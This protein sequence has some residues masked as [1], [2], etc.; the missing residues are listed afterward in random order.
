MVKFPFPLFETANDFDF[1][2]VGLTDD[3]EHPLRSSSK[4]NVQGSNGKEK[5]VNDG[6]KRKS[7][8]VFPSLQFPSRLG[9][10]AGNA[11]CI[12]ALKKC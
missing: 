8:R 10:R 9:G 2:K 1:S 3:R 11:P 4:Q 12:V 5:S 7:E 6:A